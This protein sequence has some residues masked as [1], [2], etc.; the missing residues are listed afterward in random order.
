MAQ[1]HCPFKQDV[2]FCGDFVCVHSKLPHPQECACLWVSAFPCVLWSW[3]FGGGGLRAGGTWEMAL[4]LL[5]W[6][7]LRR[8]TV[9]VGSARADGDPWLP[10]HPSPTPSLLCGRWGGTR[11]LQKQKNQILETV[12]FVLSNVVGGPRNGGW[13]SSCPGESLKGA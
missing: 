5:W 9:L 11:G 10:A 1:G 8:S 3:Q 6:G 13:G 4:H 2:S 7:H 12:C